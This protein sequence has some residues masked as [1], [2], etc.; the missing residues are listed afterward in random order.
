M[1]NHY[2]E[3]DSYIYFDGI[4]I[5]AEDQKRANDRQ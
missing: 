3:D 5:K 4:S 1:L 2:E